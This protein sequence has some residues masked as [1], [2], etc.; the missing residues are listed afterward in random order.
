VLNVSNKI[1]LPVLNRE[2]A[3]WCNFYLKDNNCVSWS[4][5]VRRRDATIYR[6]TVYWILSHHYPVWVF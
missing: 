6:T 4:M 5:G 1:L 3:I 2:G